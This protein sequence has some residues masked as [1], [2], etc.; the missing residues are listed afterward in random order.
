MTKRSIDAATMEKETQQLAGALLMHLIGKLPPRRWWFIPR[1]REEALATNSI[2]AMLSLE[3]DDINPI[4]LL[5]G[6]L[7]DHVA[8]NGAQ[9]GETVTSFNANVWSQLDPSNETTD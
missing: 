6:V 4:Y 8:S 1:N 3:F 9:K 7:Y 5:S 2:N